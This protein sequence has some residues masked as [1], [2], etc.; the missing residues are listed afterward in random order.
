MC[1]FCWRIIGKSWPTLSFI[2]VNFTWSCIS[3]LSLFSQ[4]HPSQ[5][6]LL[7]NK[8]ASAFKSWLIHSVVFF[9]KKYPSLRIYATQRSRGLEVRLQCSEAQRDRW[10][11][12]Q[13]EYTVH[14][15]SSC[16]N[17]TVYPHHLNDLNSLFTGTDRTVT[18]QNVWN[19]TRLLNS[20]FIYV[21]RKKKILFGLRQT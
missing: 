15:L 8:M 17:H 13:G 16:M 12:H 6:F 11:E 5:F 19:Q 20:N 4:L 10:L 3:E 1:Y 2:H 21:V 18:A 14:G 7:N 9:S